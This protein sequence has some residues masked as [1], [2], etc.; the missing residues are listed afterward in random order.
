[1]LL[2]DTSIWVDHLRQGDSLLS[3]ALGQ[4]MVA[5]HEWV[6]GELA[7]GHLRNRDE[8]LALLQDLPHGPLATHHEVLTL[9]H[10]EGLMGQGVGYVDVHLL[11][12]CRLGS[13]QLWTRDPRLKR[14]ASTL[15][16]AAALP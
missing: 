9:I 13:L 3:K 11:A 4:G 12:S 15:V 14:L 8:V 5:V 16:I 1:M 10:S 7:C 2:V 6:I